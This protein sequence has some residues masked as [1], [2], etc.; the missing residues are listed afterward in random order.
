RRNFRIQSGSDL[1]EEISSTTASD[2]PFFGAK[3]EW[4]GSLHPN[5]YP[6]VSSLRCSSWVTA[7]CLDP[8]EVALLEDL[9]RRPDAHAPV[10]GFTGT[11]STRRA[12]RKSI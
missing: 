4:S 1:R 2:S 12:V 5:R 7:I 6:L 3:M 11:Q 10:P 9:P 8:F